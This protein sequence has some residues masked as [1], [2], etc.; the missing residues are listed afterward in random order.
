[1]DTTETLEAVL[2][3]ALAEAEPDLLLATGDIAHDPT[4]DTYD[5]FLDIVTSRYR[6]PVAGLP[7]NHD[8]GGA[9]P[10]VLNAEAPI[11]VGGWHIVPMDTHVDDEV[12]GSVSD[13]ALD[14]L[15]EQVA[16]IDGPVCLA[17]HHPPVEVG[18]PWLDKDRV[19][20]YRA[21][22]EWVARTD[23]IRAWAFGHVHQEVDA[24]HGACR[25][26]GCPST[27]FQFAPLTKRFGI[28]DRPPGYRWLTL[29][30]DGNLDTRVGRLNGY[31]L[32]IDLSRVTA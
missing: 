15:R 23:S 7:G 19:D 31:R 16:A 18:C 8:I 13:V 29:G 2:D 5:R 21:L 30:A 10:P 6:G 12:G 9:M 27:C 24:A 32:E 1:M 17:G 25:L 4:P 11:P 3:A 28:D 22:L 20:N 14:R 26:L